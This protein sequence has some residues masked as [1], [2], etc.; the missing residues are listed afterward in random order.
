MEHDESAKDAVMR[1]ELQQL[2]D[3]ELNCLPAKYREAVVL[4]DLL[5]KTLRDAARELRSPEGTVCSRLA[6]GREM[7]RLRLVRRGAA[8]S[9]AVLA[10]ALVQAKTHAATSL[11][12]S[13][14]KT[15]ALLAAGKVLAAGALAPNAAVLMEGVLKSMLLSKLKFTAGLLLMIAVLGISAT[16]IACHSWAGAQPPTTNPAPQNAADNN[17]L[18]A[19]DKKPAVERESLRYAGKRFEYWQLELRTDIKPEV[20][21][22]AIKAVGAFGINGYGDEAT[23]TILEVVRNYNE[24]HCDADEAKMLK[25]AHETLAHM[26][27]AVLP[28]LTKEYEGG[29]KNQRHFV[30]QTLRLMTD[31]TDIIP[32]L[33]RAAKDKDAIVRHDAVALLGLVDAKA[34][35]VMAAVIEALADTDTNTRR[36]AVYSLRGFGPAAKEAVPALSEVIRKDSS[37][38]LREQAVLTLFELRPDPSTLIPLL[39]T[40][41]DQDRDRPTS[42]TVSFFI[43]SR[44]PSDKDFVR[45][46]LDA[47]KNPDSSLKVRMAIVAAFA[48]M[49]PTAK[50]AAPALRDI[51]DDKDAPQRLRDAAGQALRKIKE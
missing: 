5:G 42:D 25:V 6:R 11:I 14:V 10:A 34:K 18:R 16:L 45:P 13:T 20:R 41:I 38:S 35:G 1:P 31:E 8:L 15:A 21:T 36:A 47:L 51:V 39:V 49:G 4:C 27:A 19:D 9:V 12:E 44:G 26:G 33:I 37:A 24:L 50:A 32:L 22:E 40:F 30:V 17:D 28:A 2:L 3:Q 43:Q 7:L 23:A 48:N 29:K 46:L